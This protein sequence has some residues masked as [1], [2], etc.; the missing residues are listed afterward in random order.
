MSHELHDA[1]EHKNGP[2]KKLA[3]AI[4]SDARCPHIFSEDCGIQ[5]EINCLE[6]AGAHDL[7]NRKCLTGIVN[8]VS[9]GA[10]P[11]VIILKRFIHKRY[12]GASVKRIASAA[13][14]LSALNRALDS[15][16]APSDKQCQTCPASTQK[17]IAALK[18][19]L[20]E[21]PAGFVSSPAE[22]FKEI[23]S[24]AFSRACEKAR[25]CVNTGL[26]YSTLR[27]YR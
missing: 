25:A 17:I 10:E 4:A 14:E 12:R 3:P 1:M 18:R 19:S 8:V 26:S 2:T 7:E 21:D 13:A 20:M 6:C 27:R 16:E 23:E 5:L 11:E 9:L 24:H 22:A 15:V